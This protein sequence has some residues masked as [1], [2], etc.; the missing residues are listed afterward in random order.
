L[1]D[2][3]QIT[4]LSPLIAFYHALVGAAA[5][6]TCVATYMDHFPHIADDPVSDALLRIN[7]KSFR[8]I[9]LRKTFF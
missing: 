9:F 8:R 1:F 5:M 6:M 2:F 7:R 4:N 3:Y